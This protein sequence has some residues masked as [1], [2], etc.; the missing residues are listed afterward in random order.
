MGM[1]FMRDANQLGLPGVVGNSADPREQLLDLRMESE[2]RRRKP[3]LTISPRGKLDAP[4]PLSYAQERLW[5]LEQLGLVGAAHNRPL[6]LQLT[7]ELDEWALHRTLSDLVIR[8][9]ILRTRFVLQ[10]GVPYQVIDPPG[11]FHVHRVNLSDILDTS[12]RG[13][14]L[15]ECMEREQLHRFNLSESPPIRVVLVKLDSLEHVLLIT[16]HHIICDGWSIGV[17]MRE[18]GTLYAA[19]V[20][21]R[22]HPLP[23]LEVQYAD[24]S[25]W[26]RQ[27]LHGDMLQSHLTYWRR[28]LAGAP[29]QLQLPT[30]RPR[31]PVESFNGA[32]LEFN[33]SAAL[34][35]QLE[36]LA[37]REGATLFMVMLAAY[38]MLLSRLS[39]QPDI[40]V[41]APIAGR[42]NR[43]I[44]GLIGLFVN[45]LVL[46]T[47]L[48]GELTF[49][50]LLE[51]VK[52]VTLDA[53]SHQEL[54]FE[55][56]VMELRPERSLA[57]QPIFQ[58][59]LA[60]QNYPEEQ[61]ALPGLKCCSTKAEHGTTHVDLTLFLHG[62][63]A[64]ISAI[65]E[66]ATD[67]FNHR[68][69]E[70]M[71]GQ[72][73]ALLAGV[74]AS[75]ECP[76]ARISLL[77]QED[78]QQLLRWSS[79]Q[80]APQ[81]AADDAGAVAILERLARWSPDA[82]AVC[83]GDYVLNYGGLNAGANRLAR[84]LYKRGVRRRDRVGVYL[85]R[86]AE[87]VVSFYA[88][89]KAG[90]VYVPLDPGNPAERLALICSDAD[91]VY[92][93][94]NDDELPAIELPSV[95]YI[96][97]E[98][99]ADA[100]PESKD[101]GNMSQPV[102]LAAPA[103]AIYT[104]GSTGRPKG[105]LL[106]HYGLA[107][108]VAAQ[109]KTFALAADER[110]LQLAS[111]GFDASVF[112]FMLALGAGACLVIGSR[113]EMLPGP[114][115]AAFLRKHSV[116]VLT[117]TPSA[118]AC[119]SP[120]ELHSLR[121]LIVVG[122]E[123]PP[124]LARSWIAGCRVFNAYGPTETTIWA[125]VHECTPETIC[126]RVPIGRP[127]RNM[128]AY[129]LD[130][131]LRTVSIGEVGELFVG[132]AGVAIGYINRPDLTAER[133]VED[134][135][136]FGQGKVYRTGDLARWRGDGTLEFI[137]RADTQVKIRGFRIEP[138][139]IEAVLGENPAVKQAVVLARDDISGERRLV[140]YVVG[141]RSDAA[142]AVPND[143][144]EDGLREHLVPQL[145]EFLRRRTPEYMMPSAWMVLQR[146][147]LTPNGKVDRTALAAIEVAACST[148]PYEPPQGEVEE[149]LAR[150]WREFL[151]VERVGREDAFFELGGHSLLALKVL[152]KIDQECGSALKAIDLYQNPTI[153][154][155]AERI[156]GRREAE[157]FVDL[158]H[159]ADLE[160]DI[161]AKPAPVRLPPKAV[162]L[163]GATGFVGRFLLTQL[164]RNTDATIYCLVRARSAQDALSRI[165]TTLSK[166]DLW[167]DRFEPRIL[168]IPGDLGRPHLGLGLSTYQE[169]SQNVDSIYHCGTSM[170]HLE[171]YAM[172][173]AANVAGAKELLRFATCQTP[174]LVNYIST[175]GVFTA[176]GANAARVAHEQTPI[177]HERHSTSRGYTASKW[178]G[179]KI[180]MSANE[181]GIPCNIFR[182]GL[183]WADTQQG[184]YDELQWGYRLVKS[185][186][187]SGYG[188]QRFRFAMPP[189]PVDYVARAIVFL[190]TRHGEGGGIFHISSPDPMVE[191]V[192]ERC[193][194]IADTSLQLLPLSD[195]V[196]EIKTLQCAGRP[197]PDVQLLEF[198]FSSDEASVHEHQH[199]TTPARAGFSCARTHRELE[200]AG[201]ILA[202]PLNDDLLRASVKGILLRDPAFRQ[203]TDLNQPKQ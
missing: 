40:V 130:S 155:L 171:T 13:E 107:N 26:Q 127:I 196:R 83:S 50:K 66:Y 9:E 16:M 8:H 43:E 31:P 81:A 46:R 150:I 55:K 44:E 116:S 164:L 88:I 183:V 91:V 27:R 108:V 129:L 119:L 15:H 52:E 89:L 7:G 14:Q 39:G 147:P 177:E 153:R 138:A 53:Y 134:P 146:L 18:L 114:P 6:A 195:W 2:R 140:A 49:R 152:Y 87:C 85:N 102:D 12:E 166:W 45:A 142:D 28:Q 182:L 62:A 98:N 180:F 162:L 76:I 161:T 174:K 68:T 30:D 23:E 71:A 173:K 73:V 58:V 198:A 69:I 42:P 154:Q 97:L 121:V 63:S 194:E 165:R 92:V 118:L 201:G 120:T 84:R 48:S 106:Q 70:R 188:I 99:A 93:I 47:D 137:G 72:F 167:H 151:L 141:K 61:L 36:E 86:C 169:L 186:L 56:L 22:S 126:S 37:R 33:L 17:M 24:Y 192:F 105:V 34:T 54:P 189:T 51:R 75:P 149:I 77:T 190:A 32:V 178:V 95:E 4:V 168:P 5:F 90:A 117:I 113:Q 159:E 136:F 11:L 59:G 179:E 181:R 191:D 132:G 112:E 35:G 20:H 145:R 103:Y 19:H 79:A 115:L 65:F 110:V 135:V 197:L 111:L 100:G 60:L 200:N 64:G 163:T 94:V 176:H 101:P 57:H 158:S 199:G 80:T 172:A 148:R 193:N 202:P 122:E 170:N 175:L 21:R 128:R 104:S 139:E 143:P 82:A 157:E 144:L 25:I 29:P 67:L 38:Q 109:R 160:K 125:T 203:V 96:R 133:F 156:R 3:T 131:D 187:L 185:C 184:R 124:E 10:A 78:R 1:E 41:G 74:A 123:F